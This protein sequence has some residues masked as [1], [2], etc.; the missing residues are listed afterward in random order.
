MKKNIA[1]ILGFVMC[2]SLLF[3]FNVFANDVSVYVDDELTELTDANGNTVYPFIQNGTTYIP[4]RGISQALDCTVEWDGNNKTV[5]IYKD[6]EPDGKVFRNN[7]D[8]VKLYVDN[9]EKKLYDAN[10]TE[11]KPFIKDGTTY[12]PLRG[13]SQVLGC[14]IRWDGQ[15]KAAKVYMQICPPDGVPLSENKPYE[16]DLGSYYELDGKQL[17][18]DGVFYRNALHKERHNSYALFN[19]DSKFESMTFIAGSTGD[20]ESEKKLTFIVDG[21]IV[22]TYTIEPNS[23]ATEIEVPLNKG[24]QLKVVIDNRYVGM[25]DIIFWGE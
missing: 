12:V 18:I 11:V 8:E 1:I 10:G 25:G 2:L 20:F 17:E 14:W 13:V 23:S 15:E 4:V 19:L 3:S 6:I 22:D 9:E 5:L 16:T 7:S 21:K 24:L